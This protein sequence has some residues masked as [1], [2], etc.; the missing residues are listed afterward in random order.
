MSH[1]HSA[2]CTQSALRA[3]AAVKLQQAT[4]TSTPETPQF[5]YF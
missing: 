4:E 2:E 1:V 3:R 5:H